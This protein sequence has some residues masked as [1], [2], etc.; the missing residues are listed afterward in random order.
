MTEQKIITYCPDGKPHTAIDDID[1][2]EKV[3]NRCGIVLEEKTT[4]DELYSQ[5]YKMD[6]NSSKFTG[7]TNKNLG[8]STYMRKGMKDFTGKGIS[9]KNRQMF[10]QI[11]K[12]DNRVKWQYNNGHLLFIIKQQTSLLGLNEVTILEIE[13][14]MKKVVGEKLTRGRVTLDLLSAVIY[15][16]CKKNDIPKSMAEISTAMNIP[17]KRIYQN[18]R[19]INEAYGVVSKIPSLDS[20]V[21]KYFTKTSI[22]PKWEPE[23][24]RLLSVLQESKFH[25]GKSPS[26]LVGAV[27]R[28]IVLNTDCDYHGTFAEISDACEISD[29]SLRS[30]GDRVTSILNFGVE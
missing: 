28:Y 3:C 30:M 9:P 8:E 14:Y 18:L 12:W 17:T 22:D 7:Q 11:N 5:T 19:V 21:S 26:V 6:N 13:K 15:Y 23:V 20:Y 4:H 29:V 10:K 1:A 25:E 16:V 24:R 27:M 2:G